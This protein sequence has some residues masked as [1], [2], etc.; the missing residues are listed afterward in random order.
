[1]PIV[2]KDINDRVTLV[3]K[4]R[5]QVKIIPFLKKGQWSTTLRMKPANKALMQNDQPVTSD[6]PVR[7]LAQAFADTCLAGK[8]FLITLNQNDRLISSLDRPGVFP[9]STAVHGMNT[10]RHLD[11]A[12]YLASTNP[13]PFDI[14]SFRMFAKDNALD[15]E[16]LL[17]ETAYQC[18]ARTS[19]RNDQP[20]PSKEHVII[21]PDMDYAEYIAGWFEPGCA[22]IDTRHSYITTYDDSQ[23]LKEEHR[24]TAVIHI[25]SERLQNKGKLKDLTKKSGI[26]MSS[27]KRYKKEFQFEL[28]QLGLLKPKNT[29][30]VG[31]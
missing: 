28:E 29:V 16:K 31:I 2:E 3:Q 6:Q 1:L 14:K 18:I 13:T 25:M 22:T 30:L 17:H 15:E 24:R 11:H 10:F 20:D 5:N 12:V 7:F 19:I 9:T 21:V 8:D 26:S 27:F 4:H 23:Q